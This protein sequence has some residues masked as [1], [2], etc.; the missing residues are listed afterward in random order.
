[1]QTT[2]PCTGHEPLPRSYGPPL[3]AHTH[4]GPRRGPAEAAP[5]THLSGSS[6]A[7]ADLVS[8]TTA[9]AL[10]S[11]L[12]LRG[13]AVSGPT[14]LLHGSSPCSAALLLLL[15]V[16]WLQLLLQPMHLV[17]LP[18]VAV[19]STAGSAWAAP[20]H[21]HTDVQLLRRSLLLLPFRRLWLGHAVRLQLWT[22]LHV[23]LLLVVAVLVLSMVLGLLFVA[24]R[25]LCGVGAA[26]TRL[27][28]ATGRST[29]A[30]GS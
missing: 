7:V 10:R 11:R 9:T 29:S 26:G 6:P 12:C 5:A 16:M 24:C 28:L 13:V 21:A 22:C 19:C 30:S 8:A 17:Q 25:G 18:R 27:A 3:Q 15:L 20:C 14:A 1:M 2:A 23:L 4:P